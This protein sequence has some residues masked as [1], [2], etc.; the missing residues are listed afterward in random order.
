MDRWDT[1]L[2]DIAGDQGLLAQ[3]KGRH[4]EAVIDWLNQR[5]PNWRAKNT[6]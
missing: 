6:L 4:S 3:I 5:N 2:V 1:G